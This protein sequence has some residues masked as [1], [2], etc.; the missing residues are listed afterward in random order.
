MMDYSIGFFLSKFCEKV[1]VE[2][3]YNLK[4]YILCL[5]GGEVESWSNVGAFRFRN[6]IDSGDMLCSQPHGRHSRRLNDVGCCPL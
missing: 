4:F 3:P 5:R 2:I 1:K 6:A